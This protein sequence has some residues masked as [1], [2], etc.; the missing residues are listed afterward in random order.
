M[1]NP[2]DI[3]LFLGHLHP[4]LVHLPIGLI[5]LLALLELFSRMTRFKT[6]NS[7]SGLILALA[8]PAAGVTVICGWLLSQA[9]GYQD[10][11]LQY[12][13]WTGISTACACAVAGL[14]YSLDLK[15]AYRVCLFSTVGLLIVAGHYGGSLTHGSDYFVR[16]AP[17]RIRSWF[18]APAKAPAPATNRVDVSQ[19]AVFPAVIEP[20]FQ[21]NCVSCH[22]AE[23]S[24]GGLRLD[25]F[26]AVTKGGKGGPAV[27]A[28]KAA[29]SEL[30]R[31][32]RLPATDEDHMPPDGKPQPSSDEI[33]LLQWWIDAGAP[34]DKKVAELKATTR[35]SDILAAKF[36]GPTSTRVVKKVAP[37]PLNEVL[38]QTLKLSE[39][40]SVAL[41]PLSA[42]EPWLQCN[43]SIVG[44]NFTDAELAK[45]SILGPNLRWLD[46]GGTGVTDAGLAQ[47]GT[48]PNL[49]RLHLERTRVTDAGLARLTALNDLEYLNLYGTEISDSGLD[50][51]QRMPK[52]KQIY[53]WQTKVTPA[54]AKAFAEA[55]IDEDQLQ[56]WQEQ[57]AQ[58][59]AKI[60]DAHVAIDVGTILAAPV[61]TNSA[62]TNAAATNLKCPVSGK[63]ID[64]TK[65]VTHDGVVIAF[66][67]DDCKAEFQKDPKKYLAKLES[68]KE[69]ETT[70]K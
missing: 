20:V 15:K 24:K 65:T 37:K 61:S 53:V 56:Q 4:L 68:K 35:V 2:P 8:V 3:V 34:S 57:I 23:K 63:P 44:T 22:G 58:L 67:C 43:A 48:M 27:V 31:R 1:S 9:G 70:P 13:K 16:Y 64:P 30:I 33:A 25:K 17:A 12:H 21:Q 45:L 11:L 52:L 7:N 41:T 69:T 51:L 26:D 60:R 50:E 18:S 36:G 62:A 10:K 66:C 49:T 19:L 59:T 38:P 42:Q 46:L 47:L 28:G 5:V 39:E 54:A 55:R 6:A 32:M 40:L 14:L 29:Q